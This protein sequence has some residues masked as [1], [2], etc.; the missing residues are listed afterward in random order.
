MSRYMTRIEKVIQSCNKIC[1]R[2]KDFLCIYFRIFVC[3]YL[4]K[5][6]VDS[7][8]SAALYTCFI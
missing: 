2:V 8:Y 6:T 5:F 3:S 1:T 7:S 4:L